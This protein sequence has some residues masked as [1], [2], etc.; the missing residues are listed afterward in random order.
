MTTVIAPTQ[1]PTIAPAQSFAL[2]ITRR[3]YAVDCMTGQ[4]IGYFV[5]NYAI[6]G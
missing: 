3:V 2:T 1:A 5:R 6:V 4:R